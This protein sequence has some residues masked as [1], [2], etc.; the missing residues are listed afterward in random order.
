MGQLD[1]PDFDSIREE[2][3]FK[4]IVEKRQLPVAVFCRIPRA[5]EL[6]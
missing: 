2:P 1:F 3:R 5:G 4:G 6:R